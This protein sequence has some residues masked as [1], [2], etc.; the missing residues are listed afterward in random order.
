MAAYRFFDNYSVD[1]QAIMAPHWHQ[2]E[3]PM[4]ALPVVLCLQD[5]TEL[6]SNG[7]RASGLGLLSYEAQRDVPEPH[8][9][10]HARARNAGH[11]RRLDVG[12]RKK[13][14]RPARAAG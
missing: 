9:P 12:A 11:H 14:T 5:T 4:S 6:D 13:R 3:Q 1:W 2:T 7:Q 8:L 10:G